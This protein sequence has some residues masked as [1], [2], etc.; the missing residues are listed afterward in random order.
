MVTGR[1]C[2]GG[3]DIA[4]GPVHN[5]RMDL[6]R[7]R[8]VLAG[9]VLLASEGGRGARFL[10]G[11][12]GCVEASES[13]ITGSGPEARL[14]TRLGRLVDWDRDEL[15]GL[16]ER[17]RAGKVVSSVVGLVAHLRRGR[18]VDAGYSAAYIRALRESAT[19]KQKLEAERAIREG[20]ASARSRGDLFGGGS[21][22][23][24]VDRFQIGLTEDLSSSICQ[25]TLTCQEH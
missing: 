12:R 19:G 2:G 16:A 11:S 5:R 18:N 24:P 6:T 25:Y 20:L 1:S 17:Y 8:F 7:R 13:D 10:T 3:L 4:D 23:G 15:A 9:S 14:A 21:E 22:L